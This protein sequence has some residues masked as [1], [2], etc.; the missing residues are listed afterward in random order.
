MN[1]TVV[2][3]VSAFFVIGIVVGFIIVI[4]VSVLRAER[5]RDPGDPLDYEPRERAGRGSFEPGSFA[6]RDTAR[7]TARDGRPH[8]PGDADDDSGSR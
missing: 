4:A 7:D 3:I 8:W 6:W 5:R 2:G 1:G